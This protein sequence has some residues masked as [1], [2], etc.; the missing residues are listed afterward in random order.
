MQF[1]DILEELEKECGIFHIYMM[2]GS[3]SHQGMGM[4][5]DHTGTPEPL[6]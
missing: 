3:S 6:S 4:S 1:Q 2:T 5:Q